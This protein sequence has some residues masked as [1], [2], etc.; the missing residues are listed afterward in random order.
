MNPD[1][2]AIALGFVGCRHIDRGDQGL[3]ENAAR[4]ARAEAPPPILTPESNDAIGPR[5]HA[6]VV[7]MVAAERAAVEADVAYEIEVPA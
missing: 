1:C 2:P 5:Y 4:Y 7:A 3:G 6:S